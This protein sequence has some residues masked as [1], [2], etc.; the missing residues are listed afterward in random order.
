MLIICAFLQ[1]LLVQH[2]FTSSAFEI[3]VIYAIRSYTGVTI[4]FL[5]SGPIAVLF[6]LFVSFFFDI[7]SSNHVYM[8]GV[9]VS[10]K[11]FTYFLGLQLITGSRGALVS[12]IG[13]ILSGLINRCLPIVT[14][15]PKPVASFFSSLFKWFESDPPDDGPILLGATLEIQREQQMELLE[16]QMML[17]SMEEAM[18]T[19]RQFNFQRSPGDNARNPTV[20]PPAPFSLPPDAAG[21]STAQHSSNAHANG[22]PPQ[23]QVNEDNIRALVEMGFEREQ[24]I[25][26]LRRSNNDITAATGILLSDS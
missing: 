15:V 24:V 13:G 23:V 1:S 2:L 21:P 12:S 17:N 8:L 25:Q 26:A 18:R 19:T 4:N 20:P 5:P 11:A 16:Q 10:G 22:L 7:P 9:P 3:G 14:W 6:S